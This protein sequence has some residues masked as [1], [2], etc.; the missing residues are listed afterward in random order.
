MLGLAVA[1]AGLAAGAARWIA[2]AAALVASGYM[3][4]RYRSWNGRGWRK[5]HFRAMLAYAGITARERAIADA[6]DRPF[7]PGRACAQLGVL[8]C[9]DDRRAVVE[10]ILEE[11]MREQ[12]A[13]LA[14]LFERH[15]AQVLPGA[16]YELRRDL[17]ARLRAMRF[18]P[19]LVI[20]WVIENVYGGP[21]AARYAVAIASGDAGA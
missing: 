6:S 16:P 4:Y 10:A 5:V 13:F 15:A 12:G 3:V 1:A 11:L 19:Q 8:L 9:G 18:G 20:A 7:D 2:A 21:E 17:T 14:G